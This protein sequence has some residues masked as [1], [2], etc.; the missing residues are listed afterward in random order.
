MAEE[1]LVRTIFVL[2]TVVLGSLFIIEYNKYNDE[3]SKE[4]KKIKTANIKN[5][6]KK[7]A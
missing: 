4:C 2:G 3:N 6:N 5:R 1:I 7:I